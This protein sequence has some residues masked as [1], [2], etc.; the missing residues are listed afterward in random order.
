MSTFIWLHFRTKSKY[1]SKNKPLINHNGRS[2]RKHASNFLTNGAE[3]NY[4]DFNFIQTSFICSSDKTF[5]K[6]FVF[7]GSLHICSI[8]FTK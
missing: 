8:D 7:R 5:L 6:S 1:P 3:R 2:A 4:R